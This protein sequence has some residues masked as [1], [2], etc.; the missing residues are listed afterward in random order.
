MS[1]KKDYLVLYLEEQITIIT[2]DDDEN[3]NDICIDTRCFV[4]FDKEEN[5]Y[6]IVGKRNHKRAED[7]KFFCKKRK[8]VYSFLLSLLDEEA[9]INSYLYNFSDIDDVFLDFDVLYDMS[10]K[11]NINN[12]IGAF[13]DYDIHKYFCTSDNKLFNLLKLIKNVRY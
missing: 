8:D 11:K 1:L 13:Y 4:L 10:N 12:N 5:E 2:P 9:K 6:F 7:F 3:V